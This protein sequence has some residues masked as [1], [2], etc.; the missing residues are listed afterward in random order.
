MYFTMKYESYNE[1]SD[2]DM[3]VEEL[4]KI[5]REIIIK[6]KESCLR[7]EEQKNTISS[8]LLEREKLGSTITCLE[9]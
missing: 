1:A 9:E 5:Y 4:A 2:E 6:W 3:S 7:E 8:L